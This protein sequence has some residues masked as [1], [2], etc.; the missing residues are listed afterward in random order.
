[1]E[2]KQQKYLEL[3]M[4][5]Q[6]IEEISKQTEEL[7]QQ[8]LDIEISR[9]AL[10]EVGKTEVGTEILAQIANGIFVKTKLLDNEKLIV[11][12]G[13]DTTVE[14]TIPE[15]VEMLSEQEKIM[16]ENLKHFEM[17][18]EQYGQQAMQRISELESEETSQKEI[19]EVK[20]E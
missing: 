10:E 18:L 13:A 11:N 14:K 17:I 9:N 16:G 2:D 5:Q 8:L 19:K 7:N 15:V 4:M 6:Q 12:V 3:Q 20:I 1:M